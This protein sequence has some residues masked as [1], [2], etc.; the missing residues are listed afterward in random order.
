MKVYGIRESFP[1]EIYDLVAFFSDRKTAEEY[2]AWMNKNKGS[3]YDD[4]EVEEWEVH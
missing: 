3:A 1:H 4:Y 2:A